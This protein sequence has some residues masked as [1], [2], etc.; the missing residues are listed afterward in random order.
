MRR[1]PALCL[2]LASLFSAACGTPRS[3]GIGEPAGPLVTDPVHLDAAGIDSAQIDLKMGVGE[4]EISSGAAS[5]LVDGKLE[6]NVPSWKPKVVQLT[7]G[8]TARL[9]IEQPSS[10][11][12]SGSDVKNR[13]TLRVADT[14][15]VTFTIDCGVGDAKLDL[16]AMKLRGVALNVGVGKISL[17]LRG[18]PDHDYSVK[19][20][21]G[22]GA[23]TIYL[24]TDAAIRANVQSGLVPVKVEGLEKHGDAWESPGGSSGKPAIH[25]KVE[26]GVGEIKVIR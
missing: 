14:T 17:D 3:Y 4:L 1:I 16:G 10:T 8:H 26:G 24:P 2:A 6:Y 11:K 12:S 22:V 25:L 13:W 9:T 19:V 23:A 21:G 18:H 5:G 15:P 7:D 20:Q